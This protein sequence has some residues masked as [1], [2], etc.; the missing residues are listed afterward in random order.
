MKTPARLCGAKTRSGGPCRR[1]PMRNGRCALHGGKSPAPGPGHPAYKHG[2]R[3]RRYQLAGTLDTRYAAH[4][5][6]L[7]YIGL[8]DELAAV[9]THIDE[10][11]ILADRSEAEERRLWELVDLRRRLSETEVR[12][13]KAAAD[14]L[15]GEQIRAFAAAVLEAVLAEVPDRETVARIQRRVFTVLRSAGAVKERE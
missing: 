8:R 6:D 3:S 7:D 1:S 13:I 4:L 15:T 11:L 5:E 12:R 2:E 9:T 14:T 10:L